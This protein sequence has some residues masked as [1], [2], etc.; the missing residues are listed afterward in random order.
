[1]KREGF[2]VGSNTLAGWV[3]QSAGLLGV[4]AKRV[5]AELLGGDFLQG[6]D[7]GFPVQDGGDGALRKGRLWAFTNQEQVFYVFTATK[8]GIYPAEILEDF[9]G[10]L[11]LVDGGSEFN[12]VVREQDLERAG[13]WSHPR[14][15]FFH[16]RHH[17][18]VESALALATIHDLFMF[19][20]TLKGKPPDESE[21]RD[22]PKPCR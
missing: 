22:K 16:A 11:L 12:Q 6:D 10:E 18:P 8:E 1:M 13:C 14:T 15:Y 7:T 20:R 9:A 19:E 5:Q 17:N 2:E 3:K 21:R 4:V